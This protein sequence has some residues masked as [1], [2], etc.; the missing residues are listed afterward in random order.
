MEIQRLADHEL[1]RFRALRLRS[2]RDAPGAFGTTY[3]GAAAWPRN[4]WSRAFSSLVAFVAVVDGRDVGLVRAARDPNVEDAARLGS[5]WVAPEARGAGAGE[6]L[7][8]AVS[9]WA[10]A[11][12]LSRVVLD[13]SDDN[14]PAIALYERLGFEPTGVV[15]SFPPP[16]EHLGRHQRLL[17]LPASDR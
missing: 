1:E 16:R 3:E 13:V 5:L 2:L 10:R 14:A 4:A 9:A 15:S 12:G 11:Q 6:A 8:H 17:E 7:V